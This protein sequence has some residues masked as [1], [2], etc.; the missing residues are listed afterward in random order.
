MKNKVCRPKF[1]FMIRAFH[2]FIQCAFTASLRCN[3]VGN[4]CVRI[5]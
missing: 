4:M 3:Y 2:N 5:L 1:I